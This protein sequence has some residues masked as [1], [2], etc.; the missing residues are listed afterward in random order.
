MPD[1]IAFGPFR[2]D[3]VDG[4]LWRGD[5]E[6]AMRPR[7]LALLRHLATRPGVLV[8]RADLLASVWGRAHVDPGVVKV[9][10]R[11]VRETL[12]DEVDAPRFIETVGRRGYR[13][14]AAA[15]GI[16][17]T[18]P[19][20][21]PVHAS[22]GR[23]A[24][25]EL[26]NERLDRASA[27]S[28]QIIFVT[29][30]VGIGKTT[31]VDRFVDAARTRARTARGQC[32][33]RYGAG[34]AYLPVHDALRR[35]CDGPDGGEV[36]AILR[37][38]APSWLAQQ[39]GLTSE[40]ERAAL[41]RTL[42]GTTQERLLR[43]LAE[44]I[45]MLSVA[46][47][48]VL[49]LEDLHWSDASTI[50][51]LIRLAQRRDD[52]RLMLVGTYRSTEPGLR[53]HPVYDAKRELAAKRICTEIALD[54]L[55][56]AEVAAY[57]EPCVAEG[58]AATLG[59]AVYRRTGGNPLF[60]ANVVEELWVEGVVT[61]RD[62]RWRLRVD[63]DAVARTIPSALS[64]LIEKHL[65]RLSPEL[66]AILEA[67]SVVGRDFTAAA[68]A[69]ATREPCDVV[70]ERCKELGIIGQLIE[71]IGH[72]EW[73]DG[74]LSGR[75]RF[76]HALYVDVL[77]QRLAP[78]R[79]ARMHRLI[80][81]R[82]EAGYGRLVSEHA[83]RLAEHFEAG[84]RHAKAERYHNLAGDA[85]VRLSAHREA[86][87]HFQKALD[88]LDA[89]PN[90]GRE[91]ALHMK[92]GMSVAAVR[93][94]TA[95]D[96]ERAF[97]RAL[98]LSE[99]MRETAELLPAYRGLREY[100]GV[101]GDIARAR[102]FAERLERLAAAHDDGMLATE[103]E[104]SMGT[105][106]FYAGE[107]VAARARFERGLAIAPARDVAADAVV[108]TH[109][110]VVTTLSELAL[111]LWLLGH[112]DEARKRSATAL[113]LAE[114]RAH[115]LGRAHA[116]SFDAVLHQGLGEVAVVRARAEAVRMLAVEHGFPHWLAMSLLL[117]GW[118][119]AND[120]DA[121]AGADLLRQGIAAT[122]AI[123]AQIG[124]PYWRVALGSALGA[125]GRA[126]EGLALVGA[127]LERIAK[128]GERAH[129][130][131]LLRTRGEL[132]L[133]GRPRGRDLAGERVREAEGCFQRAL[134]VARDRESRG[135]ELPAA[136]CLAELWRERGKADEG[137]A[138]VARALATFDAEA[139]TPDV[140]VARRWLAARAD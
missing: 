78:T 8:S 126:D 13:F 135:Y 64:G 4:P 61:P 36:V 39:P 110:P 1:E 100:Y 38:H 76:R 44:A 53:D 67:A 118:T 30:E 41:W 107:L 96:A 90:R 140:E 32:Q 104:F 22:V 25:L 103:A 49:V 89:R 77:R 119:R 98:A 121:A 80:G 19:R 85:A 99:G 16:G 72:A 136:I 112:P 17:A 47:P 84:L 24:E 79:L 59:S 109:D 137:R 27:G 23:R 81:E 65:A 35:L 7:P 116:L 95:P 125:S 5:R 54:L 43:E 86:L 58:E 83:A 138:L 117:E 129:E 124:L 40:D 6:V 74:T 111:T 93:G 51:L 71:G 21:P 115:P 46:R 105:L 130:S 20:R 101:R 10:M 3:V 123:G 28:R 139:V 48:L 33:E 132:L 87:G 127:E 62:G 37:R 42:Q 12:G 63:P 52:A 114:Q 11:A 113:E 128:S 75:Y 120:G 66:R 56:A 57:V 70:D 50:E 31:V 106:L 73:P 102:T 18:R 133:D 91:L 134:E 122:E 45:E 92:V 82:T 88:L 9:A 69:A 29:G 14:R 34:E 108:F 68:V 131:A 2:L 26:L 97:A 15:I 55:S 60:M 94:Y